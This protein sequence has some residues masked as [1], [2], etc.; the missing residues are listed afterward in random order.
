MKSADFIVDPRAL[1]LESLAKQHPEFVAK[2][3]SEQSD[4]H[5]AAGGHRL[6]LGRLESAKLLDDCFK[7]SL[8]DLAS[9]DLA[10]SLFNRCKSDGS[11]SFMSLLNVA[12]HLAAVDFLKAHSAKILELSAANLAEA[13][14]LL[15]RFKK[16]N[17]RL[18]AELNMK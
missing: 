6:L 2:F 5:E 11:P 14:S 16:A 17:A 18:L 8:S 12:G 10:A 4:K 15:E 9:A 7:Q 1:M 3:E 13:T